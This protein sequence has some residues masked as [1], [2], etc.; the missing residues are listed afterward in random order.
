MSQKP[1]F[2]ILIRV[3][4]H[5]PSWW[6]IKKKIDQN[7]SHSLQKQENEFSGWQAKAV[8]MLAFN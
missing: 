1:T 7:F 5:T 2:Q 6:K 8:S 3:P 4:A